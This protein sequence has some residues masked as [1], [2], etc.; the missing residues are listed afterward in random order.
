MLGSSN[1]AV[2]LYTALSLQPF[3]MLF[4]TPSVEPEGT[5]NIHGELNCS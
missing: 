1:F 2:F 3:E 5:Q 4:M